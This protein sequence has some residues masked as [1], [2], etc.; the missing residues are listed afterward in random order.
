MKKSWYWLIPIVIAFLVGYFL[1]RVG[2]VGLTQTE[3]TGYEIFRDLFTILL[4][5]LAGVGTLLYLVIRREVREHIRDDIKREFSRITGDLHIDIGLVYYSQ[6]LHEEAIERT[7]RAL[8]QEKNLDER[9]K[10]WAKNNLAYYYAAE[11]TGY[12]PSEDPHFRKR[13]KPENK[14]EAIT[15]AKFA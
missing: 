1:R 5:L 14:N 13:P 4:A 6:G 12:R 10:I 3:P 2:P 8:Q 15:L 9:D 11:H 7:K